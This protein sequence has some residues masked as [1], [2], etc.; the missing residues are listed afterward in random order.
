MP[1]N[2]LTV[3]VGGKTYPCEFNLETLQ[4]KVEIDD[5]RQL[6]NRTVIINEDSQGHQEKAIWDTA[7]A[8]LSSEGV[9]EDLSDVGEPAFIPPVGASPMSDA[10]IEHEI[11]VVPA[12]QGP[13]QKQVAP[14]D[15]N[16]KN[17][18]M[19]ENEALRAEL[20]ARHRTSSETLIGV[21]Q[22]IIRQMV[23]LFTAIVDENEPVLC[24]MRQLYADGERYHAEWKGPDLTKG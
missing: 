14:P 3:S 20:V 19:A 9:F 7:M 2:N 11:G 24:V 22:V 6:D 15:M 17:L 16:D 12:F 1:H 13:V 4:L 18:L 23:A 8:Q 5:P 10:E 21:Q